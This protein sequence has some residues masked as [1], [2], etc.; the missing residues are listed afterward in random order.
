MQIWRK[1]RT[2]SLQIFLDQNIESLLWITSNTKA[3]LFD[4]SFTTI[5]RYDYEFE[6]SSNIQNFFILRYFDEEIPFVFLEEDNSKMNYYFKLFS[7]YIL[8]NKTKNIYP[9]YFSKIMKLY[10]T[11]EVKSSINR[12]KTV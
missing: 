9:P 6:K 7:K 5:T 1:G 8:W 3:F 12:A 10:T 11:E 4:L 2:K